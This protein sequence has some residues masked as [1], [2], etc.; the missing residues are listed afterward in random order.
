[1][2]SELKPIAKKVLESG[3]IDKSMAELM[4]KWGHLPEGSS[5]LV[6]EDALKD[7]TKDH[8]YKLASELATEVDKEHALRETNLDLDRIRWA[9][10]VNIRTGSGIVAVDLDAV[11][12]RMGR[13][14]FRHADVREEWFVPGYY[15]ERQV[16]RPHDEKPQTLIEV[17]IERQVLFI[18][19]SPVCYQ[20]ATMKEK[21]HEA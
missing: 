1:M 16:G 17:I 12:D 7:V 3:L 14:Y 20:V 11:M 13:Y 15:I 18:G 9:T 5:E 8:L 2:T 6:N 10:K 4:E 19:E 21:K